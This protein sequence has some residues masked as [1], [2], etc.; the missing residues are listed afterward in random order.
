M[1]SGDGGAAP[2]FSS[3]ISLF[4]KICP[5]VLLMMSLFSIILLLTMVPEFVMVPELVRKELLFKVPVESIVSVPLLF[6]FRK[7]LFENVV[8]SS[9][10]RVFPDSIENDSGKVK[11]AV[12]SI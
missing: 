11:S 2:P 9:I 6:T 3:I 4:D 8:F 1:P 7:A 10:L 5:L 12:I